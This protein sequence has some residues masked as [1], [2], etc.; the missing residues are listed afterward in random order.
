MSAEVSR[1]SASLHRNL[2]PLIGTRRK[3][4]HNSGANGLKWADGYTDRPKQYRERRNYNCST[5]WDMLVLGTYK[6]MNNRF[7]LASGGRQK[8]QSCST[9]IDQET[10]CVNSSEWFGLVGLPWLGSTITSN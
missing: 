8:Q 9:Q 1:L 5:V 7:L 4:H 10:L 3:Q 2:P 6:L